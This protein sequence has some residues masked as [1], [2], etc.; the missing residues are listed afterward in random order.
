MLSSHGQDATCQPTAIGRFCFRCLAYLAEIVATLVLVS[1]M[2][3]IPLRNL[4]ELVEFLTDDALSKSMMMGK[5][6]F[7]VCAR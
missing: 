6:L 2:F 1:L 5:F 4:R 7:K 3:Y